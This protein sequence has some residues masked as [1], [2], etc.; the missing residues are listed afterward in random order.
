M[1]VVIRLAIPNVHT[2][3]LTGFGQ[4]RSFDLTRETGVTRFGTACD[5]NRLDAPF[6]RAMPADGNTTNTRQSQSPP[7][8]PDPVSMLLETEAGKAIAALE[9]SEAGRLTRLDAPENA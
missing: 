7:I 5:A 3:I 6:E 4:R 2:Y 1:L 9:L 8:D